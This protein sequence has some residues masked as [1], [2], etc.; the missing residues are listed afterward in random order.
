MESPVLNTNSIAFIGLCNDYCSTLENASE[1]EREQF[2]E[3]M[4]KVLPR[5]YISATDLAV[6]YIEDE[7]PYLDTIL[8]EAHYEIVR[9]HIATLMGEHDIYLEV[10]EEDMKYSDTPV[11]AS[12]SEGLADIFQVLYD[13]L[14]TVR[15][16]TDDVTALALLSV[17]DDFRAYW[18]ATLCNV[19]RALNHIAY[20]EE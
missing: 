9:Q 15:D 10:F 19:L 6:K 2:V 1:L 16:S 8:D 3:T 4:L 13:F 5:L 12:I 20:S 17:R 11:S 14:N 7:E 18:S